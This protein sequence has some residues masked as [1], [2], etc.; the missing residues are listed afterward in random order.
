MNPKCVVCNA[1]KRLVAHHIRPYYLY[2]ELELDPENL[3]TLC[4]SDHLIFGHLR[5]YV[6]YNL[7]VAA[8]A[9]IWSERITHRPKWKERIE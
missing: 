4:E 6:S 7:N 8:D 1:K 9:A 3:V 2:P 5:N